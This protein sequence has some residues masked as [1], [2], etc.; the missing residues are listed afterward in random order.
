MNKKNKTL[1]GILIFIAF[2]FAAWV[3]YQALSKRYAP[4]E[5]PN[6]ALDGPQSNA[7]EQTKTQAPDFTVEDAQGNAISLSSF[8]GKPVVVNFWASWCGPCQSELPD[9]E[10]AAQE[11]AGEVVFMMVNLTDGQR[12]TLASAKQFIEE[13]GY[14]FPAYFDTS[15]QAAITYGI[16]SIPTTL[17]IDKDGSIATAYTG[18]INATELTDGIALIQ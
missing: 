13:H 4:N 18:I 16:Y 15:Q 6:T 9:F 17:F 5:T 10:K 1:L 7:G 2:I 12:E 11:T 14:T 8:A 3:S